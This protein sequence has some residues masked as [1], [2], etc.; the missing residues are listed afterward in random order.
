MKKGD[1]IAAGAK[2]VA[3][4]IDFLAGTKLQNCGGCNQMIVNLNNGMTL[5]E[6]IRFRWWPEDEHERP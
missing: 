5:A 2:P 3:K 4:T 6:A 1:L